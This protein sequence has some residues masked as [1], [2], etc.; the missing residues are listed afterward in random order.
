MK[1]RTAGYA[2]IGA[3][4]LLGGAFLGGCSQG[5][6]APQPYSNPPPAAASGPTLPSPPSWPAFPAN[7]SCAGPLNSF[8]T[9]VWSDVKT[10]N[11]NRS[12]YDSIA[13]DLSRAADA[14]AGGRDSEA[15]SILRATKSKHGYRA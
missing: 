14:C 8:Q 3:A 13:G 9:V 10:G 4:L 5:A 12:V 11:V 6:N 7:S 2:A 15:L 1:R